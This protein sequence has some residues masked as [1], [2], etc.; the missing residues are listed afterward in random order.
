[1]QPNQPALQDRFIGCMLGSMIG[2]VIGAAVEGESPGY[3]QK[4]FQ[5]LDDILALTYVDELFGRK[6]LVGRYTDDT[7]MLLSVAEWLLH[8]S[9]L[10][11]K[12][13]LA[14]FSNAYDF[15]RRYGSGTAMILE[16]FPKHQSN[17]TAL[18]TMMFPQ[19]SYGNGSAMRVAPVGLCFH[20]DAGAIYEIAKTSSATTHSHQWAIQGAILQAVAVALAIGSKSE[21]VPLNFLEA[22]QKVVTRFENH[23]Q[24]ASPYQKAFATMRESL[25]AS[26][27]PCKVADQ[28]GNGIKAQEA[29]PMAIYCFLMSPF[30]YE[31]ALKNA[32]F[33]GGDTDTI[34]SMTSAISGAYLGKSAI[35][36]KWLGRVRED[37]YTAERI[38]RLAIHLF[39]KGSRNGFRKVMC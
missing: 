37:S 26:M 38:E 21:F 31:T 28:L 29:V 17:W 1:M 7:Q 16:A 33:I 39:E 18:A 34:A 8:D 35:P 11:G 32:V 4:T 30:S 12:S 23:G 13:L 15:S 22:L 10:D 3:I 5:S 36:Q 9:A 6:W 20:R 19:G 25:L 27:P 2:D 14:R 24:D